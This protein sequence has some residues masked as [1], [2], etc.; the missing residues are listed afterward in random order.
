VQR[1]LMLG[2]TGENGMA[3]MENLLI[4]R[5]PHRERQRLLAMSEPVQ[6]LP[7]TLL[8]DAGAPARHVYFP[9]DGSVALVSALGDQRE[10]GVGM[11]GREGMVGPPQGLGLVA[12]P[13]RALVQ[14]GGAARRIKAGEFRR[15]LAL[16]KALHQALDRYLRI[17][18]TQLAT[19]AACSHFHLVSPR[20]ARWLLMSADRAHADSF[21]LTHEFLARMLGVRR[22]GITHAAGELQQRALIRYH[23]GM[24]LVLDRPGLEAAA[25]GCYATDRLVYDTFLGASRPGATSGLA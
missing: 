21:H 25:C 8:C 24:I 11:V 10:I 13:L 23:R 5:L 22:E 18:L 20:L 15:E 9:L 3:D 16:G 19:A 4:A 14:G 17:M 2:G 1:I 6:L 12:T 7:G